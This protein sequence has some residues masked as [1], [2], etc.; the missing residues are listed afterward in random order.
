MP[1]SVHAA[2]SPFWKGPPIPRNWPWPP[3]RLGLA[4]LGVADRNTLAGVV[5]V[6]LAA[7]E[8]GLRFQPGA[9]LVFSDGTPDI[10]AYPVNRRGWGHLCRLLSAGNLRAVKG[11]CTLYEADLH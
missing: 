11:S 6:H 4:G 5:R 9:R 1:K 3:A 7:K 8:A 2:I 10:L